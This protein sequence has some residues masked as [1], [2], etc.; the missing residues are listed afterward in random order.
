[1]R[2]S[3]TNGYGSKKRHRGAGSRGG[4]GYAGSFK[5]KRLLFSKI[6]PDHYTR[7][8]FKSLRNRGFVETLATVNLST[9]FGTTA[10]F[11]KTK[12]LGTG[13]APKGIIVKASAFSARAKEKIE[14]A[15]GKAV[16]F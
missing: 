16:E 3:K 10:E 5:H 14:A 2:G 4:R 11:P 13:V 7:K 12:V 1:M 15:G 8:K 9:L 6:D